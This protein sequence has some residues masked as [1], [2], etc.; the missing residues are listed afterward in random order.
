M[1]K[2]RLR[3]LVT[4]AILALM[5][6]ISSLWLPQGGGPG[7]GSEW[8]PCLTFYQHEP[9]PKADAVLWEESEL[10]PAFREC[11]GQSFQSPV[12]MRHLGA[13]LS[14]D[15]DVLMEPYLQS[16]DQLIL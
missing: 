16:W 4:A 7:C 6:F 3:V 12:L 2:K 15:G 14:E 13:C 1:R 5:L 8:H 10:N 11:P 9:E